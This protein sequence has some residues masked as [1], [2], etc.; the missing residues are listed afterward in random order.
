MIRGG[1]ESL[2]R[3]RFLYTEFSDEEL[4]EGQITLSGILELLPDFRIV[5]IWLDDVLLENRR[6]AR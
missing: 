4:Y 6:F 5:E 1:R 2:S 3:T